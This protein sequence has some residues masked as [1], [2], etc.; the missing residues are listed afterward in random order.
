MSG[1]KLIFHDLFL[2]GADHECAESISSAETSWCDPD[3]IFYLFASTSSTQA[4]REK[5]HQQLQRF[6]RP[7]CLALHLSFAS[8]WVEQLKRGVGVFTGEIGIADGA[9][10][11]GIVDEFEEAQMPMEGAEQR[12]TIQDNQIR[13]KYASQ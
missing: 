10:R 8:C 11:R 1:C 7:P 12:M 5:Y 2:Q 4:R 13:H 9:Q 3:C 6:E